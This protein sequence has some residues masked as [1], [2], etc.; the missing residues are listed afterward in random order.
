MWPALA[1]WTHPLTPCWAAESALVTEVN[2]RKCQ[3]MVSASISNT[4]FVIDDKF[5]TPGPGAYSPEKVPPL[6]AERRPP[7][8]TIGA[9]T[10]YRSV[11]PVPAPNR[12]GQFRAWFYY[13]G[14]TKLHF[15]TEPANFQKKIFLFYFFLVRMDNI[16]RPTKKSQKA[17]PEK[18]GNLSF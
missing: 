6:N 12:W 14:K 17:V 2:I 1:E 13:L 10:R 5:Q 11:D 9:R 15:W 18:T 8:Y 3:T 7:A 4:F 16:W